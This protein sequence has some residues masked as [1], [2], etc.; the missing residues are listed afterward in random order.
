MSRVSLFLA[1]LGLLVALVVGSCASTRTGGPPARAPKNQTCIACKG[2]SDC[3]GFQ[4]CVG[5]CCKT[6][7][8]E[9]PLEP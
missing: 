7:D 6:V 1:I 2:A 3:G 5:G 4:S 8:D 9:N